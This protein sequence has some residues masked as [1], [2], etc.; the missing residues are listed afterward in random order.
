MP[1]SS[2]LVKKVCFVEG[3][4][5]IRPSPCPLPARGEGVFRCGGCAPTPPEK[6]S[7]TLFR[8]PGLRSFPEPSCVSCF[9]PSAEKFPCLHQ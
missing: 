3:V 2:A 6:V 5:L 4:L 8:Q 7:Q 9:N 1:L